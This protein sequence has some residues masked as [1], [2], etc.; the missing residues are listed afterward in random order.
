MEYTAVKCDG[1]APLPR[2]FHVALPVPGNRMLISGGC[3]STGN[4]QDVHIFNMGTSTWSTVVAPL[5][6]SVPRAGHTL[7]SLGWSPL[8]ASSQH[9]QQQQAAAGLKGTLL[10]FGGSDCS[11][12]LYD[13]AMTY[14]VEIPSRSCGPG[15]VSSTYWI[16]AS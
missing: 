16:T 12:T 15:L 13:E 1:T 9:Q 3:G 4:L 14:Q 10:V 8:T 6:C 5:L 11:G 7:L 2:G